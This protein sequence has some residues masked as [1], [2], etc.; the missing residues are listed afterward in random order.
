MFSK[1]IF[2]PEATASCHTAD[3]YYKTGDIARREGEYYFIMGRASVDIIKSGGYK[4]SALDIEREILSL[5]YIAE[6]MVVGVPD[7]E[8]G[9]RVGAAVCLKNEGDMTPEDRQHLLTDL[10]IERLRQDLRSKIASY[11]MPTILRVIAG[12]LP[13]SPTGKVA[14]KLLGPE[15]FPPGKYDQTP[16]VQVWSA[17]VKPSKL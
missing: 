10:T 7:L 5:P 2:D 12:E 3:G 6:V 13:K 1:Y 8:Y 14:K 9:E 11:K 16:E 4:L 15:F 17:K